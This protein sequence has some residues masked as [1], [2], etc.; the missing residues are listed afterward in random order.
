MLSELQFEFGSFYILVLG[1]IIAGLSLYFYYELKNI[2]NIIKEIDEYI[3]END[4]NDK[5]QSQIPETQTNNLSNTQLNNVSDTIEKNIQ[6]DSLKE[7][8]E[9]PDT[10]EKTDTKQDNLVDENIDQI[11][12]QTQQIEDNEEDLKSESSEDSEIEGSSDSSNEMDD[13]ELI[14]IINSSDNEK[15]DEED[16]KE[17]DEEDDEEDNETIKMEELDSET[18]TTDQSFMEE[19]GNLKDE[20]ILSDNINDILDNNNLSSNIENKDDIGMLNSEDYINYSVKELKDTI[21]KI[22]EEQNK[23]I[24]VSGNKTTLI[25]RI[26]QN[27]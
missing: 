17:D 14:K 15:D 7:I 27:I 2:K 3:K 11:L 5:I 23:K 25:E 19:L 12:K 4:S 26:I 13:E 8:V 1:V 22:N 21:L 9:N 18:L 10:I 16:D 20:T 24:S 6:L